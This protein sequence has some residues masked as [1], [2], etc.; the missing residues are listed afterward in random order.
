MCQNRISSE[1]TQTLDVVHA[2]YDNEIIPTKEK[3]HLR[4]GTFTYAVSNML[5]TSLFVKGGLALWVMVII[6]V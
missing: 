2:L 5:M 6:Y 4:T 1:Y 3:P